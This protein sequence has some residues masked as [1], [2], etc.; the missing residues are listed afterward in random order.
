[1]SFKGRGRPL[2]EESL[3]KKITLLGTGQSLV[4]CP[5]TDTEIWG[6]NGAYRIKNLMP[7]NL[8]SKFRMDKLFMTDYLWSVE[9]AMNFDIDGMNEFA[10]E[11]NTEMFSLHPYKIGNH[12]LNAKP[13]PFRKIVKTFGHMYFTDTIC[14]MI[15]YALLKHTTLAKNQYG[16]VRLELTQ[17]LHLNLYGV[18]MA[19]TFEYRVSKGGIEH[20]LGILLGMGGSFSISKGSTI[21]AH[22]RGIAYGWRMTKKMMKKFDPQGLLSGKKPRPQPTE[23]DIKL[24]ESQESATAGWDNIAMQKLEYAIK[25]SRK[26]DEAMKYA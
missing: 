19:T 7:E 13:F 1:M 11:H 24:N 23:N 22:P 5:Y 3:E 8:R 14:Y 2:G 16:H 25:E 26:Y 15:A 4:Y 17:P 9:G 20:W 21:M 12:I 6:V 10:K 18:D